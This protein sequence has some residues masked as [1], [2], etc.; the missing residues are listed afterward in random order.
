MLEQF[1][2]LPA[3]LLR[4]AGASL[5][6]FAAFLVYLATRESLS[7]PAV[8]TAILLNALWTVD[9]FLLLLTGWVGP[10]RRAFSMLLKSEHGV[11]TRRIFQQTYD[12]SDECS[13]PNVALSNATS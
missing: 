5:L 4:Y 3:G 9:S 8:W 2:G 1:T 11:Y 10:A 12:R 7:A 13:V 6:P